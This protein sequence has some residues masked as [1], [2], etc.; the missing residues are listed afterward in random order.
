MCRDKYLLS[1]AEKRILKGPSQFEK[2]MSKVKYIPDPRLFLA[3]AEMESAQIT[4]P[5][6]LTPDWED[7][8][9]DSSIPLMNSDEG[10]IVPDSD[11]PRRAQERLDFIKWQPFPPGHPYYKGSNS[12]EDAVGDEKD[13]QLPMMDSDD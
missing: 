2:R 3:G 11:A 5:D 12:E 9:F 13:R 10:E 1:A 8:V 4:N 7:W 6:F